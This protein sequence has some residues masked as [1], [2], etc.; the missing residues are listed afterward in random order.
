MGNM[1]PLYAAAGK[2]TLELTA[3]RSPFGIQSSV[4]LLTKVGVR[5]EGELQKLVSNRERE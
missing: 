4:S 2:S 5:R 1:I 3:A